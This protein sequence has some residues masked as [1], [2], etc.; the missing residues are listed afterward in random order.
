MQRRA[1][2]L[3]FCVVSS[4]PKGEKK[5]D[6]S[7]S[8]NIALG[9]WHCAAF[10]ILEQERDILLRTENKNWLSVLSEVKSKII[11]L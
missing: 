4:L 11:D 3:C 10:Q 2:P 1:T 5:K 6:H 7:L 9:I 8:Y